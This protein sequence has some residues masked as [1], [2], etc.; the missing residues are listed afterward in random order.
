MWLFEKNDCT[1][2]CAKIVLKCLRSAHISGIYSLLLFLY[3]P[4]AFFPVEQLRPIRE[5]NRVITTAT[6]ASLWLL[7]VYR[8]DTQGLSPPEER[9]HVITGNHK[10][11][12]KRWASRPR[13]GAPG[14]AAD[15]RGHYRDQHLPEE[16]DPDLLMEEGHDNSTQIVVK[17]YC[18]ENTFIRGIKT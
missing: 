7:G 10:S 4:C 18:K 16:S 12:E 17:L 3:F 2:V 5:G 15:K 14:W 1:C 13:S 6:S 11:R 9:P 8:S